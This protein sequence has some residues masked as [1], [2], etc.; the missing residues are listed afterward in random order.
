M[1]KKEKKIKKKKLSSEDKQILN[2]KFP[3]LIRWSSNNKEKC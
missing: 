2:V 1:Y 3:S